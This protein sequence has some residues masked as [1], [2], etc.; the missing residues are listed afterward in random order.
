V[1]WQEEAERLRIVLE[2]VHQQE[3][4][5]VGKK[6]E[7][8][9]IQKMLSDARLAMHDERQQYMKLKREHNFMISKCHIRMVDYCCVD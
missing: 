5:L 6:H 2:K 1:E 7:I 3:S 9:E 8:A 4:D